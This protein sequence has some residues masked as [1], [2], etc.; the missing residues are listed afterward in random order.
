M[1]NVIFC[2]DRLHNSSITLHRVVCHDD[3]MTL[4]SGSFSGIS[5]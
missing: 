2:A 3:E 1:K 4:G 5:Q